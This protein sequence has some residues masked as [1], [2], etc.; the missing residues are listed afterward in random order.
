[1][2][3]AEAIPVIDLMG[4]L[5]F[6]GPRSAEVALQVRAAAMA[7]GFFYV[8]NHGVPAA[9]VG[10]QFALAERFFALPQ[11][12]K[13]AID[14]RRSP[15]LRGYEAIGTQTLDAQARPDL[16]E[17]FYCGYDYP[18]DHPYVLRGVHSYGHNQWPAGLPDM[19]AQCALYTDAMLA[20]SFRLMQ[21][22]ALSL[23][24]P[25]DYFDRFHGHPMVTLRL[26]RYPPHPDGADERTFGAGAH[27]DWG[28]VTILAQD[29]HG[30]LEVCLPDGRWVA[31]TPIPGSFVV[32]L[33]DLIPRWTNGRYHSNPHRVRNTASAG[34]PRYSIPFFYD[35]DHDAR[36]EAVPS[37]VVAG[38][39]A[40]FAPCTV[41]G[42]LREMY[43]KTYGL[44]SAPA[45]AAA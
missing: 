23:E 34:A 20:L 40:R 14:M 17:S 33:G 45:G 21:L 25:E 41:G 3:A 11:A 9:L 27:T 37:C 4:A 7:S 10:Q 36:I 1:M 15:A 16:K 38:Q 35:P 5:E 18:D 44:E 42:H 29:A 28:A 2:M 22:L 30:G 6:A 32:N 19:Q 31:A 13:E 8:R 24:L 43:E 26:L 12:A 39:A